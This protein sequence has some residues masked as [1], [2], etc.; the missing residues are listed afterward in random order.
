MDGVLIDSHPIHKTTWRRFLASLGREVSDDELDFVLDGRKKDEILRH[1]LGP[2]TTEQ[3]RDYGHQKEMMFREESPAINLV[4]GITSFLDQ[5]QQAGIPMGLA[6]SG[7][8]KRVQYILDQLDLRRR[9]RVIITGDDVVQGKPDP[10]IFIVAARQLQ[11]PHSHVL[12]VE[13]AVAGVVAAK[14]T[15]MKCL[16]IASNGRGDLLREAGADRVVSNFAGLSL[17]S[18][19]NLGNGDRRSS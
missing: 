17:Q 7:S 13:D 1:F 4:D 12:V 16:G 14:Q 9:F 11:C 19:H 15:G 3:I 18:L 5:I 6:T 10:A 2:L 8:N